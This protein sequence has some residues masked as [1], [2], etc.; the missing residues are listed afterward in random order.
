V[1]LRRPRE[2]IRLLALAVDAK[3]EYFPGHSE[4]VAYVVQLMGTEAGFSPSHLA[5]L[6]LAAMLH[7]VGKLRIPDDVLTAPRRLTASEF[8]VMRRHPAWG[9]NIAAAMHGIEHLAPWILHHHEHFDG[10]G[11]PAG[12]SGEDIPY[13]SRILLVADAFHVMTSVRPYQPARTRSEAIMELRKNSG[14]QFC[15]R[16]V[17]LLVDRSEREAWT[18][19]QLPPDPSGPPGATR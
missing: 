3:G 12:L 14:T 11:Y 10:G 1:P 2:V 17:S 4:G 5:D 13:E 9:A 18:M 19:P 15:P 16:A 6:Q 8:E 7:D